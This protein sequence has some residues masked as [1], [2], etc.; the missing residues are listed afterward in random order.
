MVK[1]TSSRKGYPI[2][3][4]KGNSVV[5]CCSKW[6]E[7]VLP[8][9]FYYPAMASEYP[10]PAISQHP[11]QVSGRLHNLWRKRPRAKEI[12]HDWHN[13]EGNSERVSLSRAS[14]HCKWGH[15]TICTYNGRERMAETESAEFRGWNV[16]FLIFCWR[17]QTTF[18]Q[19]N[20]G[21]IGEFIFLNVVSY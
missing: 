6:L 12:S 19:Q 5:F 10:T 20:L 8:C 11:S 3:T 16:S 2:C 17:V 9:S 15:S 7:L 13:E 21:F 14:Q 4:V 1:C 18:P